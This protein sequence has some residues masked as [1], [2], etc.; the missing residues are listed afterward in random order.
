[1]ALTNEELWNLARNAS[2]TFASH[3]AKGTADFFTERGFDSISST[4]LGALNEFF[5]TVMQIVL[6]KINVAKSKNIFADT[7]LVEVYDTPYGG[8]TQRMAISSLKPETPPYRKLENGKSVDMFKVR[9][10]SV[11]DRFWKQNFDYYSHVT[12]QDFQLKNIFAS[13]YGMSNF[14]SGIM[15]ALQNGFTT[16]EMENTKAAIN[17]I[18][19][20]NKHPLKDTQKLKVNLSADL[21]AEELVAMLLNVRVLLDNASGVSATSA[22]NAGNFE[23]YFDPN[24]MIML[25]RNDIKD[26]MAVKLMPSAFHQ[27]NLSLPVK[28]FGVTD[29]GGI[30]YYTDGKYTTRLYPYY[31]DN[32]E[33]DGWSTVDASTG[34]T[35]TKYEGT[36]VTKDPN[37]DV[38]AMIV[39][40]GIIFENVQNPYRV[41]TAPFNGAGLY[42]TMHASR[43]NNTIAYDNF[44][45][46][47]VLTK[48]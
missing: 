11:S 10:P 48:A 14:T 46:A 20:D 27:E 44:Y 25:I 42:T 4:E 29:F 21:T 39:Q 2:P 32:G 13:E 24:E 16:Q 15:T 38:I 23:S 5:D 37:A 43:P 9:K 7:G 33:V 17:A 28:A 35:Q 6:Q 36:Y 19:H 8:Y 45:N 3:T 47:I 12:L 26:A 22:F 40:K 34:N 31:N 1:M 41:I 18:L 30:E